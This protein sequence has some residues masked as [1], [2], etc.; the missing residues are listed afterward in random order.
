MPLVA[1]SRTRI[2]QAPGHRALGATA[3][4]SLLGKAVTLSRLR[5]TPVTLPD[6]SECHVT[7]HPSYLLRIEDEARKRAE[8]QQFEEELAA[9]SKA[10]GS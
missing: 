3:A 7:I 6:G 4:H 2:D 8:Y 5:G 1:R 10:A 9:A